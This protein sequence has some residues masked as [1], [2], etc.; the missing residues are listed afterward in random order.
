MTAE[1]TRPA[2]A[3]AV[4]PR[5]GLAAVSRLCAA[6]VSAQPGDVLA[7]AAEGLQRLTS[8]DAVAVTTPHGG[9]QVVRAV[10]GQG[11]VG[12][13]PG[14]VLPMENTVAG[15]A[16]RTGAVQVC[17]DAE[18]DPRTSR[19]HSRAH[20]ISSS[21]MVPL[22]V[23]GKPHG[24]VC[25]LSGRRHAFT[26][27][28]VDVAL[29]VG[30]VVAGRLAEAVATAGHESLLATVFDALEE[31]MIVRTVPGAEVVLLNAAAER[32]TNLV[33]RDLVG[34]AL[35]PGWTWTDADGQRV[36][37]E[38]LP[39]STVLAT[40]EPVRDRLLR[41]EGAGRTAR[42]LEVT[43]LPVR[44]GTGEVSSVVTRVADVTDRID[45]RQALE[46]SERRLATAT[47]VTG[48]AWWDYDVLADRHTWS[49]TMFGLLG[50]APGEPPGLDG[51]LALVH[52]DD[53]E[54]LM[55]GESQA[56]SR[57]FRIRRP[58]GGTR[59]LQSWSDVVRDD[60]GSIV[61]IHG[62]TLDVTERERG[63]RA[64]AASEEMFRAAF[65]GAPIGMAIVSLETDS[66]GRLLRVN[67]AVGE[68]LG[69]GS[70]TIVGSSVDQWV[71]PGTA[72]R[73]RQDLSSLA[74]GAAVPAR[75]MQLLRP[76]GRVVEA[77]VRAAV[78]PAGGAPGRCALVHVLDVT[79]QRR[80]EESLERLAL[81]DTLTGLANRARLVE[82]MGLLLARPPQPHGCQVA[83]LLLDLDRFKLV[84]DGL[85]HPVGDDLLVAVAERLTTVSPPGSCV[86]R[87]GGDEFVVLLAGSAATRA[88]D[89]AQSVAAFLREPYDLPSG[90]RLVV[91]A[92]VGV[93][94]ADGRRTGTDLLRE[95]DLALY[96]AKDAG[97]DR[98][99]VCDDDLRA[100]A[101]A[102]VDVE[103][104]L[105]RALDSGGLRLDLQP[106]VD[107][108][109]E[110][111]V[112]A[113]ALV[114][115][116]T[117]EGATLPPATFVQV[118]EETG[119]VAQVD[120][121]VV[122]QA[123][124]LLAEPGAA[125]PRVA[126]NVSGRTLQE[127]G[128]A[129]RVLAAL[130]ARGVDG[131]RLDV[132]ITESVLL[133]ATVEARRALAALRLAGVRIGLD[134]FGTGYSALAY[135]QRLPLDFLKVDRSFVARLGGGDATAEATVRAII[136]VAHAHRLVVIAEGVE[137]A[138][139]ARTLRALG[140]DRGQGWLYGRPAPVTGRR[141]TG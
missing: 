82:E 31:G 102:R 68:M 98:V 20:R 88:L 74:A 21:V 137:T 94:L 83:V 77:W 28:D 66:L 12:P 85:G 35:S 135:L 95:A 105:R 114:R 60:E 139:Q 71:H 51:L 65:E 23:A 84:N 10:S 97:R 99:A 116:V 118:A 81:T 80:A 138:E 2:L 26:E 9:D 123:V 14:Q 13:A 22:L 72:D 46:R 30:G 57:V 78:L 34:R 126:V 129:D 29:L 103:N 93:A 62:T 124:A 56:G 89:V 25:L 37:A 86:G 110:R 63:A 121:W 38:D 70:E 5:V 50:L 125:L 136:D 55:P 106:V 61:A 115:L 104:V 49:D 87:L 134:D 1:A 73:A 40:G 90:H 130:D 75:D 128:F 11:E 15:H 16:F 45:D 32:I 140:C 141:V 52:P 58:D 113:E 101:V 117:V 96:R 59:Y 6:L 107:L 109:S 54:L 18:T 42:W 111:A 79:E 24:L 33:G 67:G 132:E 48:L 7:L 127:P 122:E 41:C 64:V 8:A 112:G 27:D 133:E 19:E 91:S 119:L 3:P 17:L 44:T 76:D 92:S 100:G 131:A 39:T 53:R 69:T 4:A 120:G 108:A 43:A 47:A 36:L